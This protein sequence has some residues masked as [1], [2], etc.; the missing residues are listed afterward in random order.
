MLPFGLVQRAIPG[1]HVDTEY[2]DRRLRV[3][4]RHGHTSGQADVG[5]VVAQV[6]GNA[7]PADQGRA[8]VAIVRWGVQHREAGLPELVQ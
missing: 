6:G 4:G 8:A 5:E 2:R 1:G 3:Q 7:D